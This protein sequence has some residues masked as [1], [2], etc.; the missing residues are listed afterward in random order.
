MWT[1]APA[2]AT[3]DQCYQLAVQSLMIV[4]TY[5]MVPNRQVI[6]N[7]GTYCIL[8]IVWGGKVSWL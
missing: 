1:W 6:C 5:I 3:S 7:R 8:Q 4:A 2:G